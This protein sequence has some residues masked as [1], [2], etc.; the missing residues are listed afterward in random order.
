MKNAMIVLFTSIVFTGCAS[1]H[2][3]FSEYVPPQQYCANGY[4]GPQVA[5]LSSPTMTALDVSGAIVY[6]E[7]ATVEACE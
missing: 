3:E 6:V 1:V 2:I 4:Q 7:T 5:R